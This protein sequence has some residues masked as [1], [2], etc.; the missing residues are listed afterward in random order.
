MDLRAQRAEKLQE[1]RA[2]I[3]QAGGPENLTDEQ[4]EQVEALN[5]EADDLE[6][7]IQAQQRRQA[8]AASL[9][10]K[11][12]APEPR[13]VAEP[14]LPTPSVTHQRE[15]RLD[16]PTG[17]FKSF[18]HFAKEVAEL[19]TPGGR[20]SDGVRLW[21]AAG[22][23]MTQGVGADGGVT[24]PPAYNSTIWDG[25][26]EASN[27]LISMVDL[28]TLDSGVES[29]TFP[30][31]DETS[32]ADGSRWGGLQGYWKS[33]LSELSESKP[34]LREVTFKPQ[35]LY[36][37]AYV[38]DKLLRNSPI[39]LESW[40]REK[41]IDEINFKIGDAIINGT[42]GGQPLGWL[43][44][45]ALVSIA[46]ETGQPAATVK[47]A[48][49]RKMYNAMPAG[50]RAGAAWFI[51]QD[52]E[53]V[54]EDLAVDVGAGG[55]P[56]YLPPG[57]I[58]DAPLARLRNRPVIPVEYCAALGTVGDIL[59]ANPRMYGMAVKGAVDGQASMHLKFDYAQTAFRFIWEVDGQPWVKS[60]ITA[61]KGG[62]ERSPFVALAT[63]S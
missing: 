7:Q 63:R 18:G 45:S 27:S 52:V 11:S 8:A 61:Y 17:G 47:A 34:K 49:I 16:D 33:E 60:S 32:R 25:V 37:F 30:A 62:T 55:Q 46:K 13:R 9:T 2:V 21:A 48:N 56:I 14:A 38:S 57:G 51:N 39:A 50:L 4:L 31:I 43:A 10:E 42:G 35:E 41:A 5:A 20:A 12:K 53:T 3:E 23:G 28:M 44:S 6:Q 19:Q 29:M 1:A 26:R 36:V 59:F 22:T 15:S 24:V 54:L 40:L 58:A